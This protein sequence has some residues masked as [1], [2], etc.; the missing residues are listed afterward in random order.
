MPTLH[1]SGTQAA[2]V[3]TEH[4][5]GTDPDT[6]AGAFQF[7][8]DKTNMVRGDTLFIR[9]YNKI[10]SG[11]ATALRVHTFRFTDEQE[12]PLFI[13]PALMLMGHGWRFSIDQDAGAA[14][15]SFKWAIIKA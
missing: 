3:G 8:V 15:R 6:T 4:F 1:A 9:I 10:L 14:G 2:T 5:L 13:S 11:D 7:Q 12:D